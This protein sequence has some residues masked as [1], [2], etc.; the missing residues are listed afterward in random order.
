MNLSFLRT[1]CRRLPLAAL[2]C[3]PL[4]A[5]APVA[6]S[7]APVLPPS[8]AASSVEPAGADLIKKWP[9][10]TGVVEEYRG[11]R[12]KS[13]V[14][15][16]LMSQAEFAKAV[17]AGLTVGA[18]P[19]GDTTEMELGLKAFGLLPQTLTL[20]DYLPKLTLAQLAG[21]YD[22][23][24]KRLAL[25]TGPQ[26][27]FGD[28]ARS[29]LGAQAFVNSQEGLVI[30][31][32]THALQDQHF[33][34]GNLAPTGNGLSDADRARVAL[35]EG[36]ATLTMLG[37]VAGVSPGD[38]PA[39]GTVLK[40]LLADPQTFMATVSGA[41]GN[42]ELA[43]APAWFR[44]TM[45][46][47]YMQG[48][49]FCASVLEHGGQRLLD[50]AFSTDP[51]RSTE[52]ILHPE[53]W[54]GKPDEPAA[55]AWPDL[56]AELTGSVKVASG[57]LGEL[58]I[59]IL[60]RQGL[61]DTPQG[62][63]SAGAGWGGDQFA[64]YRLPPAGGP[65]PEGG[66]VQQPTLLAW[67]T[68]WDTDEA[69]T[70]FATAATALGPDWDVQRGAARRVIVLRGALAAGRRTALL[71]KLAAAP[72]TFAAARSIDPAAIDPRRQVGAVGPLATARVAAKRRAMLP[73]H[74]L[75]TIT[76]SE[77]GGTYT[78]PG[79]GLTLRL[80]YAAVGWKSQP[81]SNPAVLLT[82]RDPRL[83][84]GLTVT[85]V[86]TH[87]ANPSLDAFEASLELGMKA[88]VP[89]FAKLNGRIVE[90][91]G[92]HAYETLF[93]ETVKGV[94]ILGVQRLFLDGS[95]GVIVWIG[96]RKDHW[97]ETQPIA[98]ILFAALTFGPV[99]LPPVTPPAPAALPAP[100]APASSPAPPAP[101]ARHRLRKLHHLAEGA[102]C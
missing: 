63:A 38:L 97:A 3:L 75:S 68:E 4:L 78:F 35:V 98:H 81:P 10:L 17:A 72:A 92:L 9:E 64:V 45:L 73:D 33:G 77:D 48:A 1:L 82:L 50:Y 101:P 27:L 71:A 20:E 37:D 74:P 61:K 95:R 5:A 67:I 47:S 16:E 26:S 89:T 23:R 54:Y 88:V 6:P 18:S 21:F 28:D 90:Q 14:P 76:V 42:A 11:L 29:S 66:R 22:S 56:T 43:S 51:P 55:I 15:W 65:A 31:E 102:G 59:G 100:S 44:E 24:H 36:D 69:A 19:D 94:E 13:P 53:K 83:G 80:P 32:L 25:I 60:L 93:S 58:G 84:A 57:Q 46:F 39:M 99:P 79:I 70:R 8:P 85:A 41:P 96:A 12:F 87:L 30:H 52:Q 49:G 91:N 86:D 34:L 62:A 2:L 40:K 7:P